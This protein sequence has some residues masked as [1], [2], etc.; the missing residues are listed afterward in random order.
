[1]PLPAAGATQRV[2]LRGTGSAGASAF[3]LVLLHAREPVILRHCSLTAVAGAPE[4][5]GALGLAV[6][7]AEEAAA[8][9][10]D[11]LQHH[12]HY[13]A[14]ARGFAAGHAARYSAAAVLRQLTGT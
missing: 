11:I 5:L 8:G 1:V 10:R 7:N 9:V 6:A 13:Q 3:E 14:W 2:L 4:P 12:A